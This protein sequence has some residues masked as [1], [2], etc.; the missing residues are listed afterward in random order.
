M[1]LAIKMQK[2]S[3][4]WNLYNNMLVNR[5]RVI[6]ILI[7]PQLMESDSLQKMNRNKVGRRFKFCSGLISAAFAVKC[8]F[9]LAY[10][11]LEGFM[12]DVSDKLHKSIPNFRTIWWRIDGMKNEG[13]RFSIHEGKDTII[14]IDSTGLR[15][16]NDGEYRSMRYDTRKEW[17]KLHAIVDVKTKEILS[18]VVTKGNI[19]DNTQFQKVIKPVLSNVSAVFADKAYDAAKTFDFCD[20][21]RIFAG[22][23]VKVNATNSTHKCRL[24][25]NM[26]EDQLGLDCKKGSTRL[27]R[28]LTEEKKRKNQD[29][30][31][32]KVGYGRRSQIESSFSRYKR[33]LGENVFSRKKCN[34]EKEITA[35]VNVL[36]RFAVMN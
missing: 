30:W 35:K 26:I 18:T 7:E 31:K 4:D 19:G 36:N 32:I 34:I 6:T 8:V 9:R 2:Y 28:F 10:R 16:V 27:N 3:R 20:R 23:P 14:A 15:P 12:R 22:I 21:N 13:I 11:Q 25:R 5:G 17:I 29:F 33:I 1:I 24:R